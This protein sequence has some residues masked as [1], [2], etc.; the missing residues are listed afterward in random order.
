MR[1]LINRVEIESEGEINGYFTIHLDDGRTLTGWSCGQEPIEM[2]DDVVLDEETH[3][4]LMELWFNIDVS[5]D[6]NYSRLFSTWTRQDG[7]SE[8]TVEEV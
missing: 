8:T 1:S 5:M 2:D 7:Q 4:F 6:N 3:S